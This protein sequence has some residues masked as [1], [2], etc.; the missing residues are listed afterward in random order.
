M[1]LLVGHLLELRLDDELQPYGLTTRQYRALKFIGQ[2]PECTRSDLAQE[3]RISRQAAGGLSHRMMN[4]RMLDRVDAPAGYPV[5]Y[6]ITSLGRRML[7]N[8]TR[9]VAELERNLT[10]GPSVTSPGSLVNA[11]KDLI[12]QVIP[13][14]C[15]ARGRASASMIAGPRGGVSERP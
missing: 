9:V 15:A 10:E 5:A 7:D 6:F 14:E 1:V 12:Q 8:A 4:T 3:L 13:Q 2:N 11:M